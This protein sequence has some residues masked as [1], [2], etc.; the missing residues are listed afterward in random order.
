MP[1]GLNSGVM[2]GS[3]SMVIVAVVAHS[4][5]FGVKVYAVVC[6][7]LIAGDQLPEMLFKAFVGSG[8]ITAPAQ[9]GLRGLNVGSTLG[10]TSMDRVV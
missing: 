4:P 9:K 2:L 8:G 3:I 6:W 10:K 5:A 1:G 7:L